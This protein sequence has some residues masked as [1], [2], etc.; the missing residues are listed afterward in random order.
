MPYSMVCCRLGHSHSPKRSVM[1]P[2]KTTPF[3]GG[4]F[5]EDGCG[6]NDC[7]NLSAQAFA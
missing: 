1:L 7:P 2:Q 3:V 6:A 4:R 5:C